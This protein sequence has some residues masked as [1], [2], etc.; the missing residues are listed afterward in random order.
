MKVAPVIDDS[1]PFVTITLTRK[2]AIL[3]KQLVQYD[4]DRYKT[5]LGDDVFSERGANDI[6]GYPLCTELKAL[7]V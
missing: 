4:I 7:G 5:A 6:L 3:L 1:N 2:E